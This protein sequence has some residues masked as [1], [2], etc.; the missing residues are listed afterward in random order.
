MEVQKARD[1]SRWLRIDETPLWAPGATSLAAIGE[2][3][4]LS[5]N[6]MRELNPQLIR[7]IT[8]PGTVYPLRVPVG[9]A[10]QAMAALAL[11][12]RRGL[13]DD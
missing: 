7:G 8:P 10:Y 6:R 2:A 3:M 11:D 4:G 13:A 5:A 1:T 9:K 12:V